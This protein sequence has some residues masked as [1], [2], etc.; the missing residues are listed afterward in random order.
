MRR[1]SFLAISTV[2]ARIT[3]RFG[4]MYS[5]I[6][7]SRTLREAMTKEGRCPVSGNGPLMFPRQLDVVAFSLLAVGFYRVFRKGGEKSKLAERTPIFAN[8]TARVPR[9]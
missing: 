6:Q 2:R 3:R 8:K 1:P 5:V 7:S 9:F 4:R